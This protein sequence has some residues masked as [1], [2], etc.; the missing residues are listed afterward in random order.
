MKYDTFLIILFLFIFSLFFNFNNVRASINDPVVNFL[1]YPQAQFLTKE[2]KVSLCREII[3]IQDKWANTQTSEAKKQ[4]LCYSEAFVNPQYYGETQRM[5]KVSYF[6]RET[7]REN[8]VNW[9]IQ[10]VQLKGWEL[11]VKNE[12]PSMECIPSSSPQFNLEFCKKD[13]YNCGDLRVSI[14]PEATC[15]YSGGE[16]YQA[17]SYIEITVDLDD[18]SIAGPRTSQLIPEDTSIPPQPPNSIWQRIWNFI[19]RLFSGF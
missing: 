2:L 19:L 8:I 9:F 16:S 14:F 13:S 11:S 6:T 18:A 4:D 5:A 1:F 17:G 15:S 12:Y 10:A 3:D 7:A